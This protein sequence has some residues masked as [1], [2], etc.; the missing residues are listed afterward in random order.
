MLLFGRILPLLIGNKVPDDDAKW[1]LFLNLMEI[2]DYLFSPK[3]TEDHAAY[4]SI[5]INDHHQDFAEVYPDY[6]IRNTKDALHDSYAK[7]NDPVSYIKPL[8]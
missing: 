6:N 8:L 1:R 7:D 4:L 2:M 3:I 5:L